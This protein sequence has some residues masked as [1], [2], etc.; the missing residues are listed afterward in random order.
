MRVSPVRDV[1]G[2]VRAALCYEGALLKGCLTL[3]KGAKLLLSNRNETTKPT[4][5]NRNVWRGS[6]LSPSVDVSLHSS[7]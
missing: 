1:R 2:G 5:Q 4:K 6:F 3:H 7:A